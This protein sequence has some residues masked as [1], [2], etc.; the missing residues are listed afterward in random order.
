MTS[1]REGP[2]EPPGASG[3][4]ATGKEGAALATADAGDADERERM[5][6]VA[7]KAVGRPSV[8]TPDL[9]E[10]I[11]DELIEGRSLRQI[12]AKEGMPDRR[13]VIRW[14]DRD[15]AFATKCAR[16]REE[17]AD[18]MDD[19]I[20]EIAD[21]V[22]CGELDPKAASVVM[23]ALMWRAAK[24]KPK[25][26]GDAKRLEHTGDGGGPVLLTAERRSE[27]V[28]QIL[29]LTGV[30]PKSDGSEPRLIQNPALQPSTSGL[31]ARA[32]R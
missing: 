9:A 1:C 27:L 12:C 3:R 24:L 17:Q 7:D 22:E 10:H 19:R 5:N 18:L 30:Q 32:S 11:C 29:K 31:S 25:R 28:A 15:P 2:A 13:T 6:E 8:Y 20:L 16:A 21:K 26:Y 14:M 4:P 23:S